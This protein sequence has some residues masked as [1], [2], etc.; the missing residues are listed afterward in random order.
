MINTMTGASSV[1]TEHAEL[2]TGP[3]L[4]AGDPRPCRDPRPLYETVE[5]ERN[6]TLWVWMSES[7]PRHFVPELLGELRAGQLEIETRLRRELRDTGSTSIRYQV[8]GSRVPGV[9]SLG[10]DLRLFRRCIASGDR[11][12]LHA[13]ACE[14]IALVCA[15]A[16]A[17]D[18]PITTISLVQGQAL[19]GGFEAA[20]A[21]HVVVAERGCKLGL[22]EV[23]FNMFPG[24][25]AYQL[26]CRRLAP[27]QAERL[28]LG[29]R[30]HGAEELHAMGLVDVLAEPGDGEAAV[31]RYIRNHDR[32]AHGRHGLRRAIES[33]APFD[34][35]ALLR[36]A[37]VWVDTAM[38]LAP[39][40]LETID[41]LVRA[42][43]RLHA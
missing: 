28:I 30:T 3:A 20:L 1:S 5:D 34:R 42:Q 8:F 25:G 23:L 19:G 14:C 7:S 13:Y 4:P 33:A 27:V 11:D 16:R 15:N 40:D 37:D 26:L 32:Q 12:T 38:T 31:R 29:G 18:L 6:A 2:P 10:G 36:V 39:R 35:E 22:P 21:A 43:E 9:F 17:Y 24:M 41:Y